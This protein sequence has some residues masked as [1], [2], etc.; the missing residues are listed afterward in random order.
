MST[1]THWFERTSLT[2]TERH[3]KFFSLKNTFDQF[4]GNITSRK[5]FKQWDNQSVRGN[6]QKALFHASNP[7]GM[8]HFGNVFLGMNAHIPPLET[9]N[10]SVTKQRWGFL[11]LI[12][13]G[14]KAI[15]TWLWRIYNFAVSDIIPGF[16]GWLRRLLLSQF[17]KYISFSVFWNSFV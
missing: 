6:V 17:P 4:I 8:V 7:A 11:F 1:I 16:P 9:S 14:A 15:D 5:F 10:C 3:D 12:S 2:L 13:F